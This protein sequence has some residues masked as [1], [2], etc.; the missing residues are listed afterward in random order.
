VGLAGIVAGGAI[1]AA[2]VNHDGTTNAFIRRWTQI[3]ADEDGIG[4][5]EA[6]K[7]AKEFG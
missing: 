2:V 4:H 7:C 5:E 6:R 1:I 3:N